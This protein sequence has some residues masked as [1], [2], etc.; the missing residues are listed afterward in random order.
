MILGVLVP[1]VDSIIGPA[2]INRRGYLYRWD[3]ITHKAKFRDI[4]GYVGC[5]SCNY[6]HWYGNCNESTVYSYSGC[7]TVSLC[8]IPKMIN[9]S[10]I[11]EGDVPTANGVINVPFSKIS[12]NA[13]QLLQ[14]LVGNL[15]GESS[16][17]HSRLKLR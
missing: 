8:I 2:Y 13:L 4:Y 1:R 10:N 11:R 14:S 7:F 9:L 12:T 5:L 6:R 16:N 17:F 3:S 15:E